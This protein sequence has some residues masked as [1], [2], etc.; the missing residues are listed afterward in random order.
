MLTPRTPGLRGATAGAIAAALLF[1][2]YSGWTQF[3][4]RAYEGAYDAITVIAYVLG[5]PVSFALD[6]FLAAIEGS[7]AKYLISTLTLALFS[8]PLNWASIASLVAT[9]RR[10]A[11]GRTEV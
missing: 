3:S 4:P 10:R 9:I 2:V 11:D 8:I 7:G 1:S 5:F 6:Q